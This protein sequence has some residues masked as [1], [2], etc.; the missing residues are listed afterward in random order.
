M[1]RI[2]EKDPT[3]LIKTAVRR[4]LPKSRLGRTMLSRLKVYRGASH[5]HVAQ[6]PKPLPFPRIA[7][8]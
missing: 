8:K 1:N 6:A 3:W 2:A 4:M 5:P 7:G